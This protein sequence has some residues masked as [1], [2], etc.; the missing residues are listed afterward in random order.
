[1]DR[2][3]FYIP[4]WEVDILRG[5]MFTDGFGFV[6]DYLAEILRSQR[7][8]D[9]SHL[10]APTFSLS[11]DISTRDRDAIHKTFSGLMKILFPNRQAA[12]AETEELL[13]FAIEG[14]KR[15]KD[16]LFRIDTTYP[17]VRFAYVVS[18]GVE[19]HVKT[20]EEEQ[21]PSI[22]YPSGASADQTP[23]DAT[24]PADAS[25]PGDQASKTWQLTE[26]HLGIHEN[27]RGISFDNLFGPYIKGARKVVV[28]DPYI[29]LFYQA[30]NLMDFLET[31]AKTKSED[32]EVEVHLIT[33]QR[34]VSGSRSRELL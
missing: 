23:D 20:L 9:F 24:L 11:E 28:T 13:R 6:V 29:R 2:L 30:R 27:Q 5:E 8:Y 4:G 10:Y 14:R 12:E 34:R 32:E 1:M 3:H 26:R 22:Y 21:Y 15:I 18:G 7:N 16:Q 19:K 17:P 25:G 31:I 33:V